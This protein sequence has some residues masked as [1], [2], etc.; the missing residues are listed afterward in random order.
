MKRETLQNK[1]RRELEKLA[2]KYFSKAIRLRDSEEHSD[3]VWRGVCITCNKPQEV[4]FNGKWS[5][6]VNAG[7]FIGRSNKFLRYDS[8]NVNLQCVFCNKWRSGEHDKYRENL[9]L[10]Y[11]DK[12]I[13]RLEKDAR[14]NRTYSISKDEYLDVIETSKEEIKFYLNRLA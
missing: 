3:G 2:D 5:K 1:T 4:Y 9:P 12:V 6:G 13:N 11:G 10:K 14:D 8:E 7:H